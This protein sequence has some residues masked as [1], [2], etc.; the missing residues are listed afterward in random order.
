MSS[1]KINQAEN[2]I[3][4]ARKIC[5]NISQAKFSEMLGIPLHKIKDAESGKVKISS[6]L[7]RKIEENFGVA[8]RW[9]MT[10]EGEMN[11]SGK[12]FQQIGHTHEHNG[13]QNNIVAPN[14]HFDIIVPVDKIHRR[15]Q[16]ALP[17]TEEEHETQNYVA[18]HVDSL[19]FIKS[20]VSLM[21][22]MPKDKQK[23]ALRRVFDVDEET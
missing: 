16:Q 21:W 9:L 11:A 13:H 6:E 14:G 18:T 7:A 22:D 17:V 4:Q 19:S 23:K 20:V 3:K 15:D 12:D 8:Y 2:R 5:N 1:E 10:G